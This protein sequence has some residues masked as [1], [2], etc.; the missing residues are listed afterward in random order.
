MRIIA[1][2]FRGRQLVS[3][4]ADHIRPTTDRV[5]E[6]VFNVLSPYFDGARVLDLYAGTGNLGI[7]ALSRG[8]NS[9][10]AVEL[11][12]KSIEIIR[13]NTELVSLNSEEHRVIKSDV[14]QYL[15][16]YSG[17]AYD[18]I[19]IDP[20]FTKKLAHAS[21]QAISKSQV[22]D[23]STLV[24]IESSSK[25]RIDEVYPPVIR[26]KQKEYGDKIV[27]YFELEGEDV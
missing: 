27:S 3:F 10:T 17:D 14:I 22:M 13:K 8:A 24:M 25:E 7:E 18:I 5:K 20:P 19:F 16:K 11:N 4:K 21:M 1:G 2:K 15:E 6:S 9:V 23:S 12:P 26:Y